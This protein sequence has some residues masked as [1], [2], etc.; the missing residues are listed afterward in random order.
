MHAPRAIL[1]DMDGVLLDSKEVWFKLVEESGTRFRG[2]PVTREEFGPTFGQGTEADVR[3]FGLRCTP[4]E[5]DR[6]YVE[7][8]GRHASEVWVNPEAKPVL[9]ALQA[10]GFRLAVVTNTVSKLAKELLEA[11]GLLAHFETLACADL[12]PK[13]KPAPDLVHF[14]CRGLNV[15]EQDAWMIGD[16]KYDR[17]SANAAGVYFVGFKLDGD[18]RVE[19]LSEL[20]ATVESLHPARPRRTRP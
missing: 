9:E 8:F 17:G 18:A 19:S 6:F 14:A 13:A 20:R 7:N 16:S 5:L 10:Q 1:F 11:S 3:V 2:H 12:V 4:A 15:S